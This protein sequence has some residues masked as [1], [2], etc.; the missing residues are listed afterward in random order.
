VTK[1]WNT[2][3]ESEFNAHRRQETLL[4]STAFRSA[5]GITQLHNQEVQGH[6]LEGKVECEVPT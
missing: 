3:E 6:F 4:F 5:L 1:P 2:P